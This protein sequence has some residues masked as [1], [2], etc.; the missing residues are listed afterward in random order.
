MKRPFRIF[1]ENAKRDLPHRAYKT[2][3]T[4]IDRC[5]SILW[6]L[7]VGNTFTIYNREGYRGVIQFTR[8]IDAVQVLADPSLQYRDYL[9]NGKLRLPRGFDGAP[10]PAGL[11]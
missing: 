3:D 10:A 7:D 9:P 11:R 6:R 5:L 4:A 2:V 1:D 8:K